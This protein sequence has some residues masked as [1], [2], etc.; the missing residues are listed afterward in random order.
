MYIYSG[1]QFVEKGIYLESERRGRVVLRADG[2][3]PG[4]DKEIYFRLPE[5]YLLIPVF[6]FGLILS[7]ALPYGI[8]VALFAAMFIMHNMIMAFVSVCEDAFSGL[9][10]YLTAAYRPNA[11]FFSGNPGKVKRRKGME[12]KRKG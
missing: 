5:C 3:L 2:F 7:M 8:G 10:A 11:S 4:T 6:L 1:G 9:A 12:M